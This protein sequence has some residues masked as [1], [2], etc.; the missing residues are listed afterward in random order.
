MK[1]IAQT[2]VKPTAKASF[3]PV[4][5]ELLQRKCVCGSASGPDSECEECTNKREATGHLQTK[6][7]VGRSGDV[8]EREADRAAE[9]VTSGHAAS[10][11]SLVVSYGS[12]Q[13]RDA[14]AAPPIVN[15]V[16]N[17]AGQPLD[18]GTRETMGQRFGYDFSRVRIH[19]DAKANDSTRAVS[20]HAYTVGEHI[21]FDSG[22]YSP[23]THAGQS[24]LAHELSHVVQQ[25]AAP[26]VVQRAINV[27]DF[28]GGDFTMD[29]LERYLA[30]F[31]PGKIEDHNDSDDKARTIVALWRKGKIKLDA[32][33]KILL[34]QEMQSGFTGDDDERAILTLLL[35]TTDA[36]LQTIF[37]KGGI[38]SNE[39]DG[40]FQ[41]PEEDVLR[42]FYDRKCEG[43]RAVALKGTCKV[44]DTAGQQA[45]GKAQQQPP[46]RVPRKN[47][48]DVVVLLDATLA[49]A[50]NTVAADAVTL[51]PAT[52]EELGKKLKALNRPI[53]TIFYFGHA[54][55]SAA[56]K[57]GK[58][59]FNADKHA[60]GL[61]GMVPP[62]MEPEL[63]DFRGCRIG[64]TPPAMEKIRAALGAK[65]AIG[66]TCWLVTK[67]V[68]PFDLGDGDVV[69]PTRPK[70]YTETQLAPGI[71]MALD[72]FGPAKKCV[73]DTTV[74]AY[75]RAGGK[76]VSA[77]FTP[78]RAITQ[79]DPLYSRCYNSLE[80]KVVDPAVVAKAQ[81]STSHECQLIKVEE[82]PKA[83]AKP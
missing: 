8:L 45:A 67:T 12:P 26:R 36:E 54:D 25:R 74:G 10:S 55:D 46:A 65:A 42:A 34:I 19:T 78:V 4:R 82:K 11:L 6:L 18:V 37:G 28:E 62:G 72:S 49:P 81:A 40:D 70:R 41:G 23:S 13:A 64:M 15:D 24:L 39:L 35:N 52:P 43:G 83:E 51:Q 44:R 50:A 7:A 1:A 77:W 66:G 60:A 14:D 38:D 27:E 58:G 75:F 71:K 59:W 9:A 73:L 68:G 63:A 30:N 48:T 31:G 57:F 47:E 79:F 61:I 16:L 22:R 2:Q 56:I 3:T 21:A 69:S 80:P 17:S 32:R 5:P 53:K 76:F 33:K 20:A 29:A